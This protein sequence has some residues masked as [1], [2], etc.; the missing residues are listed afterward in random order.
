[1]KCIGTREVKA[2]AEVINLNFP[3]CCIF[4]VARIRH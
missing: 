4:A 2:V 3:T 1:M